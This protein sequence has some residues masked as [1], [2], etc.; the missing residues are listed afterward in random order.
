M[1]HLVPLIS[2][3][4]FIIF[5]GMK[6]S[7][8]DIKFILKSA[9]TLFHMSPARRADLLC[10]NDLLDDDMPNSPVFPKA[11]CGHRWLENIPVI[12]RL[13]EILPYLKTCQERYQ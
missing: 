9:H 4:L 5:L 13:L 2:V 12:Q 7:G 11:Y 1:L 10:F 3:Y 6:A 8:W